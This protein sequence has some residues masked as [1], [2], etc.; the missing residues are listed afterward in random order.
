MNTLLNGEQL[1][2]ADVVRVARDS[3]AHVTVTDEARQKMQRSR[4]AVERF[5]AEGGGVYGINTGFGKF[6]DRLIPLEA[7]E[8]LQRNIVM[9]HAVGTGPLLEGELVRALLLA[10]AHMLA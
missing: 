10:H 1:T 9:S 4:E 5:V 6:Q 7:V 3:T 8:Q 2:I